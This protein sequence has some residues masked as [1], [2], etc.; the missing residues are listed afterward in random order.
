MRCADHWELSN[1]STG[2]AQALGM[3]QDV[4]NSFAAN[5]RS[6]R[7]HRYKTTNS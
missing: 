1:L 2:Y 5:A 3:Y 7:Y 4:T 6:A